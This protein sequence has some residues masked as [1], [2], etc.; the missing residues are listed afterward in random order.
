MG[1]EKIVNSPARQQTRCNLG[2]Y[3]GVSIGL[4]LF[5][6][7][8]LA[9]V[10]QQQAKQQTHHTDTLLAGQDVRVMIQKIRVSLREIESTLSSYLLSPD[11]D[12]AKEITEDISAARLALGS[13]ADAPWL[14]MH[15]ASREQVL[16][17]Q[18]LTD[19]LYP[20]VTHLI[21]VRDD[22]DNL[23]LAMSTIVT[24]MYPANED[25]TREVSLAVA[26]LVEM[27]DTAENRAIRDLFESAEL[28]WTQMISSFRVYIAFRTGTF[29]SPELGMPIYAHDIGLQFKG[30]MNTLESLQ[31]LNDK[32]DI[33]F[34]A[35]ESLMSM[36]DAAF[37]WK[38]G[39]EK[40]KQIQS[41]DRWRQDIPILQKR[42][43]PL[44]F[45]IQTGLDQIDVAIG[46][47]YI[48]E[49]IIIS[50]MLA[51][52]LY[53]I[54]FLLVLILGFTLFGLYTLMRCRSIVRREAAA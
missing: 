40:V 50:N 25:F 13:L 46:D 38:T 9:F 12:Q 10:Q 49:A 35:S 31:V 3:A 23:F 21:A 11:D 7:A 34:Q 53:Q 51:E 54:G 16:D 42:V 48:G 8:G 1:S 45:K 22:R 39:Y 37:A 32:R 2:V 33:G 44:F 30:V 18:L 36:Q 26:E 41:S 52:S 4:L 24:E 28:E 14:K 19:R 17:L 20:A 5:I 27:R 43:R 6:F 15:G 47:S 29:G